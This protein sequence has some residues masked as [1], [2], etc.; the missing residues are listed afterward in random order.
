MGETDELPPDGELVGHAL[1][2][3]RD[4]DGCDR[5]GR[6]PR[7]VVED[8]GESRIGQ[9]YRLQPGR[10]GPILRALLKR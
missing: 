1:F 8:W 5:D 7:E 10:A 6:V 2:R 3:R 4:A 9:K